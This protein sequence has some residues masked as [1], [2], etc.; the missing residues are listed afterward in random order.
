[1]GELGSCRTTVMKLGLLSQCL[2]PVLLCLAVHGVHG[3]RRIDR[4]P[5]GPSPNTRPRGL[6]TNPIR[7]LFR[8]VAGRKSQNLNKRLYQPK[9]KLP[10]VS[11]QEKRG[12]VPL[13]LPNFIYLSADQM[14]GYEKFGKHEIVRNGKTTESPYFVEY[15]ESLQD[16]SNLV[17]ERTPKKTA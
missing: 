16:Y 11:P 2:V 6:L 14:P 4:Y 3:V 17:D 7:D 1:M 8:L 10:V 5:L 9:H 15:I 12:L 13:T